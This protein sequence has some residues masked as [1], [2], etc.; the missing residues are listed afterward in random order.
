VWFSSIEICCPSWPK[1]R[2]SLSSVPT[3]FCDGSQ[4][5]VW[6]RRTILL[7]ASPYNYLDP[8]HLF[9]WASMGLTNE[10]ISALPGVCCPEPGRLLLSSC[11]LLW[12]CAICAICET[13]Y[14]SV[15]THAILI[16]R[17]HTRMIISAKHDQ[18]NMFSNFCEI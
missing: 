12:Q 7:L 15:I 11:P 13:W 8:M 9:F 10:R 5:I 6:C 14:I 18:N 4:L 3:S 1:E 2:V 17:G 16:I